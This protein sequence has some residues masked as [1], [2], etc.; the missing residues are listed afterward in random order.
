MIYSAFP[1]VR[2]E[3]RRNPVRVEAFRRKGLPAGC[4]RWANSRR[5]CGRLRFDDMNESPRCHQG[6]FKFSPLR[7]WQVWLDCASVFCPDTW[8]FSPP[9]WSPPVFSNNFNIFSY[10]GSVTFIKIHPTNHY[11]TLSYLH[12]YR[13]HAAAQSGQ[14]SSTHWPRS[15]PFISL[16]RG[17]I[18]VVTPRPLESAC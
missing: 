4:P 9:S 11:W 14:R 2:T 6:D 12:R 10:F 13:R 8:S 18:S 5:L 3:R 1:A 16:E 7:N 17:V 15:H